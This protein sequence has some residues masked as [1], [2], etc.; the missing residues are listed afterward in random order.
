[1]VVLQHKK[2]NIWNQSSNGI[3]ALMLTH[4]IP[5]LVML[6]LEHRLN[7]HQYGAIDYIQSLELSYSKQIKSRIASPLIMY[8]T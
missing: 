7:V 8:L 5:K 2:T 3:A 1:M 6:F 4:D